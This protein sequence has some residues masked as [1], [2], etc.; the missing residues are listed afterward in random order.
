MHEK[1]DRQ[2]AG[3]DVPR[4]LRWV[5]ETF[6][7][8]AA[9]SSSFQAQSLPLLHLVA[10][11]APDLTVLF[12]DTGFHFA[13]TL[14]LRDRLASEWGLRVRTI[15]AAH[16][17]EGRRES[18]EGLYRTD[19]DRCCYVH[20]VEPMDAAM[21]GFDAWISGVRRDQTRE[22]ASLRLVEPG[23][24]PGTLRIHPL[25]AWTRDDVE[26]YAAQHALPR[27]PLEAQGYRSIGCEPCTRPPA[28]PG[29]DRSGRWAGREKKECGLH[30]ILRR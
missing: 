7:A 1:L 13:D 12:L 9:L 16:V 18:C 15:G 23:V 10:T 8:R 11:H 4:I 3:W 2:L 25:A 21:A 20:K 5:R 30:T 17:L 26:A 27:H 6:G 29:D 19:P 14:A 22:R 28:D 24:R